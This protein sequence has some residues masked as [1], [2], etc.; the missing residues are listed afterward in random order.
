MPPFILKN[1]LH[2]AMASLSVVSLLRETGSPS[3]CGTHRDC[4]GYS[5]SNSDAMV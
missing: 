2:R 5:A 3:L 4:G 1:D